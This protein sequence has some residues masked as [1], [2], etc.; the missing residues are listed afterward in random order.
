MGTWCIGYIQLQHFLWEGGGSVL[1]CV[2]CSSST[3]R[4]GS[5]R[6]TEI[7]FFWRVR[8]NKNARNRSWFVTNTHNNWKLWGGWSS[9]HGVNSV[10]IRK[11]YKR[12]M[13][14][15]RRVAL[16][17]TRGPRESQQQ[18]IFNAF[19]FFLCLQ[20]TDENNNNKKK[21]NRKKCGKKNFFI[22]F[23]LMDDNSPKIC[24]PSVSPYC[25]CVAL[26]SFCHHR[27]KRT[28]SRANWS[29]FKMKF[30]ESCYIRACRQTPQG[31]AKSS[32]S[33]T[34]LVI[35]F[36]FFFFL[37]LRAI[38]R[39]STCDF[40]THTLLFF[41]R[42]KI[43]VLMTFQVSSYRE[44]LWWKYSVSLGRFDFVELIADLIQESEKKKTFQVYYYIT[45]SLPIDWH[46]L[47]TVLVYRFLKG[48]EENIHVLLPASTAGDG[49]A[50]IFFFLPPVLDRRYNWRNVLDTKRHLPG[51]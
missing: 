6:I 3:Y 8:R 35:L 46:R 15:T 16:W 37:S 10:S 11:S 45:K 21:I 32:C 12:N 41:S 14:G 40:Y 42:E 1:C 30:P 23:F 36:L 50:G 9:F 27:T 38:H 24:Y 49:W 47:T 20:S 22:F 4:H 17:I 43:K 28:S 7:V 29:R 44:K 48:G 34:Y 26:E 19:F 51:E 39:S 5:N 25:V 2:C 13:W 31:P 33:A 18:K